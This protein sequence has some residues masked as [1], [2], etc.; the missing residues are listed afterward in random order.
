[1]VLAAVVAVA[2]LAPHGL[3][4][5][6]EES[7][8]FRVAVPGGEIVVTV[9]P[10]ASAV[11]RAALVA[12]IENSARAIAAVFGKF[13]VPEARLD[14]RTGGR[15]RIHGGRTD[16]LVPH[17]SLSL[18][19][20]TTTEDL[21][22]D[23]VL[24]HE[25]V[26]LATPTLPRHAMWFMEGAATYVEPLARARTG[27]LGVDALWAGVIE[28]LPNGLPEKGDGGLDVTYSWGRTYWGGAL[29]FL[30]AD[31]EIRERSGGRRSLD[32]A[33]RGMLS[34]GGDVRAGWALA[35]ALDAADKG[36]G[37][38]LNVLTRLHAAWGKAAVPVDLQALFKR[39]GVSRAGGRVIYDDTAPLAQVRQALTRQASTV[40]APKEAS[41][42]GT[43]P[44]T[45][46]GGG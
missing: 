4:G 38:G 41:P 7:G 2:L 5:A 20:D 30:L 40:P 27:L 37:E 39:L 29:F 14:L 15:G 26:H 16:D 1:M 31:L 3:S 44:R 42:P 19:R 21:A 36:V 6:A 32:D 33:W 43:D 17:V 9:G 45:P 10:D 22:H 46:R 11:P 34:A 8:T 18:G 13:G 28:G 35:Q 24:T 23:W 25:F 12:W